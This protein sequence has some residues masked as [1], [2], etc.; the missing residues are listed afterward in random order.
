MVVSHHGEGTPPPRS[1]VTALKTR[2]IDDALLE[3]VA[4]GD[5]DAFG[6]LYDRVGA[7]VHGLALRV[8]RDPSLAEEVTQ[9]VFLAVW[10]QAARYDRSQSPARS[11]ILTIAHRRAV[12]AVRREQSSRDRIGRAASMIPQ[13]PV[14]VVSEEVI[15]RATAIDGDRQLTRALAS[16]T[17]LQRT[18]IELA[19]FEGLTYAQ[20][21]ERLQIPVPTAKT[22]IRDGLR[23]LSVE[24]TAVGT[25]DARSASRGSA[26]R[27]FLTRRTAS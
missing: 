25:G 9:E 19:Y 1:G 2:G 3:R 12:D 22:R 17:S 4:G 13:R 10:Q 7:T 18:A 5:Q 6:A 20:V 15:E 16:L 26:R 24:L 14:D 11:W 8:V 23:R 27:V 21:A